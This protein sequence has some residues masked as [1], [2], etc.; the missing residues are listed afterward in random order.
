MYSLKDRTLYCLADNH[1]GLGLKDIEHLINWIKE[2]DPE[3]S[4]LAFL[5]DLFHIWAAPEKFQQPAVQAFLHELD[6]FRQKGGCSLLTVGNRDLLFQNQAA[7]NPDNGLPFERI[8]Q[9]ILEVSLDEKQSILLTHGDLV[10]S[11]DEQ[12]LRWR[13]IVKSGWFRFLINRLPVKFVQNLMLDAERKMKQT[14]MDFRYE[15]PM[16]EWHHFLDK[17]HRQHPEAKLLIS[18]HFHPE[19]LITTKR[20]GLTGLVIPDTIQKLIYLKISSS[21]NFELVENV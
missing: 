11:K 18:G 16:E 5:G 21:L 8:E 13:K 15:F 9:N 1:L 14:N 2:L 10:N 20:E 4:A 12:Y 7:F 17:N 19:K 6:L 3:K